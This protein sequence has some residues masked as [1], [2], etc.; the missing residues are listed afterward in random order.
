MR[1]IWLEREDGAIWNLAPLSKQLEP[2]FDSCWCDSYGGGGFSDKTELQTL[3]NDFQ[4]LETKPEPQSLKFTALFVNE[5]H[6]EYF[7][8]FI[9]DYSK[10][11]K[12]YSSPDGTII[13][14]D[15]IS[16]PWYHTGMLS[17][18]DFKFKNSKGFYSVE[19]EFQFME[20]VWRRDTYASSTVQGVAGETHV[21]NFTYPYFYA[22]GDL[23]TLELLNNG[24]SI[25]C[26][27]M[28]KNTASYPLI[29]IDYTV[30]DDKSNQ[31]KSKWNLPYGLESGR[32]LKVD[33]R[34]K[35]Q[36]AFITFENDIV[37][38]KRFEALSV[39]YINY[40]EIRN[41]IN[42]IVFNLGRTTG[43]DVVVRY[44][45]ERKLI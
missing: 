25:G 43:V 3:G 28:I 31:Q 15:K 9:G 41:G 1:S 20:A 19:F 12:L 39:D 27:I 38:A 22:I 13:P 30:Y 42:K 34:I 23:L 6:K 16:K 8:A 21:Y 18:G 4:V 11:I 2:S 24:Q 7:N 35:S 45:E 5:E 37:N 32:M 44:Q 10:H 26:E 14:G 36:S 29:S 33:S 17:R 40:V